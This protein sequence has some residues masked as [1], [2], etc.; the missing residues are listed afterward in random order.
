MNSSYWILFL[1]LLFLLQIQGN[2]YQVQCCYEMRGGGWDTMSSTCVQSGGLPRALGGG[3]YSAPHMMEARSPAPAWHVHHNPVTTVMV[4]LHYFFYILNIRRSKNFDISHNIP[5][6]FE[7]IQLN[8]QR[9]VCTRHETRA[10]LLCSLFKIL[11]IYI[12]CVR[13]LYVS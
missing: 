2:C 4:C 3:N 9:S 5:Y 7:F 1:F 6:I 13:I 10:L 11:C 12:Y 8:W